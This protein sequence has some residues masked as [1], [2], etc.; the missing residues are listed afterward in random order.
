M[1][2]PDNHGAQR[3]GR[4]S[5]LSPVERLAVQY[6][7]EWNSTPADQ[8]RLTACLSTGLGQTRG[9]NTLDVL[10]DLME[11]GAHYGRRPLMRH[12]RSCD[13]LGA[14]EAVFACLVESAASA[15]Y[16]DATMLAAL[17]V[18]PD[19]ARN[20]VGLAAEFGMA[21]S[22]LLRTQI[23]TPNIAQMQPAVVH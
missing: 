22:A 11:I 7:R 6:L 3:V 15:E 19:M 20:F 17:I 21:L 10:N 16:E 2:R 12:G 1:S 14:D 9:R 23:P 4:I 13:C 8:S 5:D 18:R